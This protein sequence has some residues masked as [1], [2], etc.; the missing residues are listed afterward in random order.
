MKSGKEK[1]ID[2]CMHILIL[3]KRRSHF[4]MSTKGKKDLFLSHNLYLKAD[5]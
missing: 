2:L 3:I 4:A 5:G 1:P